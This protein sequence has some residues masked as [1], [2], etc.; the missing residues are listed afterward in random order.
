M[1]TK[2]G[3]R[4]AE[5]KFGWYDLPQRTYLPDIASNGYYLLGWLQNTLVKK[6]LSNKNQ[7]QVFVKMILTSKPAEHYSE[8]IEKLFDQWQQII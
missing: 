1:T 4:I 2:G 5:N 6:T 3:L 8:D 7:I